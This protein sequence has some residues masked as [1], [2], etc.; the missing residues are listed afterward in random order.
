MFQDY[1][2]LPETDQ[3]LLVSSNLVLLS[4][5]LTAAM[6][7]PTLLWPAQLSPLLGDGEV[8]KLNTKLRSLNVMGLDNMHLDF[9][10]FF[11]LPSSLNVGDESLERFQKLLR[12]IGSWHQVKQSLVILSPHLQS[13]SHDKTA[14][15]RPLQCCTRGQ[16]SH[17][18][19]KLITHEMIHPM[20]CLSAC[21]SSIHLCQIPDHKML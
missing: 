13:L 18:S 4:T 17:R 12:E 1:S 3:T 8:D 6:F 10:Q 21:L 7:P 2:R 19:S 5:L 15:I 14:A 16:C 20:I 11:G 9:M